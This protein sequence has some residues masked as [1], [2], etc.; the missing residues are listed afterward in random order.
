MFQKLHYKKKPKMVREIQQARRSFKHGHHIQEKNK[1]KCTIYYLKLNGLCS[2]YHT[3]TIANRIFYILRRSH[4]NLR[5]I[6][7]VAYPYYDSFD[8]AILYF[9]NCYD[10][11]IVK[12]KINSFLKNHFVHKLNI[13]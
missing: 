2:I 6:L 8:K 1:F 12:E 9:T 4:V 10:R 7:H 13:E 11:N 3:K 5:L